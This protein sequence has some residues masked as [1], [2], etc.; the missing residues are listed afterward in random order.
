M[1]NAYSEGSDFFA[2][3]MKEIGCGHNWPTTSIIHS[4]LGGKIMGCQDWSKLITPLE[5]APFLSLQF[6]LVLIDIFVLYSMLLLS[7]L[8]EHALFLL[9]AWPFLHVKV[10]KQTTPSPIV[11]PTLPIIVMDH[12]LMAM[13][14]KWSSL[15]FRAQE[16]C[17]W[18]Q[19]P[20]HELSPLSLLLW[21]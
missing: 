3:L 20:L 15:L 11:I 14:T 1:M 18:A 7:L 5:W 21:V 17:P 16:F 9:A 6:S 19:G 2:H 13:A 8:S 4:P 10:A 12:R